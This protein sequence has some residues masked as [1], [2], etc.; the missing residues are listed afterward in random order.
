MPYFYHS[1]P[2][3][4]PTLN[5]EESQ[6][7]VKVLRK[8]NGDT[9]EVIDGKGHLYTCEITDDNFRKCS[10][11][12]LSTESTPPSSTRSHIA[13]AP[14]KNHDRMEWFAE[15]AAELG[16]TDISIVLT[17]RCER[18][19][20]NTERLERK[21]VSAMKQSKNLYKTTLHTPVGLAECI[22]NTADYAQRF[23]AFVDHENPLLLHKE[24]KPGSD[25]L[26]LIGPEGDFTAEE[27]DMALNNEFKKISLGKSVLR[28]ETAG[29][30]AAHTLILANL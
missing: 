18:K 19:K 12:I 9:I 13:I 2:Q 26:V 30:A 28:T 10:F 6:H 16:I 23:I 15:K 7:C 5:S 3:N 11:R 14:T 4:T 24:A 1:D 21:L 25:T 17:E 27:V 22:K 8:R 29:V 20:V